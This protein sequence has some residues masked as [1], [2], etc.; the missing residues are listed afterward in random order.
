MKK[1]FFIFGLLLTVSLATF[2]QNKKRGEGVV[3]NGVKWATRNVDAPGTFAAK[4]ENTGMFY[5]WNRKKG[6][7]AVEKEAVGWDDDGESSA[8]T[9]TKNNDPC[10]TGWRLP[11]SNEIKSLCD[12]N[13]VKSEWTSVNGV[14]GRSFTDKANG[15]TLFLPAAGNLTSYDS[16]HYYGGSY[17]YYWGSTLDGEYSYYLSFHSSNVGP[18]HGNSRANGFSCRCVSK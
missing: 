11:T 1:V 4:P 12:N 9:W 7:S 3:I 17:G 6:W 15:N 2:S 8:T 16:T 10:P 13:K 18:D 5:Q 14:N